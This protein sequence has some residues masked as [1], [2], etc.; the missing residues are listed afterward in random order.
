[1]KCG[2]SIV[3][4]LLVL[5]AL[6]LDKTLVR[7]SPGVAS[8][9]HDDVRQAAEQLPRAFGPWLG[10]DVPVPAGA[11]RLLRPNTIISRSYTNIQTGEVVTFVFVQVKDARDLVGHYPPVCYAGHG[12][13][14]A[15]A[16]SRFW[17]VDERQ[18]EAT[19]YVFTRAAM[20]DASELHVGSFLLLPNGQSC[21]DMDT[22]ESA[23]RDRLRQW[24]GA[25]QVQLVYQGRIAPDRQDQVTQE[26]IGFSAPLLKA[27]SSGEQYVKQ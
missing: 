5:G 20:G 4:T 11:A 8:E 2:S 26:F 3:A 1:M 7:P 27:V 10:V 16:A 13:T 21:P 19:R 9:Y 23:A 6:A 18:L 14:L 22:L 25:A 12:W 15:S 17:S 24:F